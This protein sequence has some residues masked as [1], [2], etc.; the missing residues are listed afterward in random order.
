MTDHELLELIT[1]EIKEVKLDIKLVKTQQSENGEILQSVRHAQETQTAQIDALQI[2]TLSGETRQG[3]SELTELQ[4][5]LLEMYG[6]HEAEI[7]TFKRR[8]V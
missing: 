7:R 1:A 4:K 6:E 5:S 2:E 3:F 8:P